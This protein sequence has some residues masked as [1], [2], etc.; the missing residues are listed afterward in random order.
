MT[1]SGAT[2][3]VASVVGTVDPSLLVQLDGITLKSASFV[4]ADGTTGTVRATS[5]AVNAIFV[6]QDLAQ[7]TSKGV[8]TVTGTG[9]HL[10]ETDVTSGSKPATL[11]FTTKGG[12]GLIPVDT[13]DVQ[14]SAAAIAGSGI[15]LSGNLTVTG[16]VG[17]VTLHDLTGQ[18]NIGGTPASA[19]STWKLGHVAGLVFNSAGPVKS[20][21]SSDWQGGSITAPAIGSLTTNGD[22]KRLIAG[23]FSAD[24]TVPGAVGTAK[25]A[26][27]LSG[28]WTVGGNVTSFACAEIADGW[29]A[30]VTGSVGT[31]NGGSS[32]TGSLSAATLTTFMTKGQFSGTLTLTG[33]NAKGVSLGAFSAG[34]VL[35]GAIHAAG[36]INTI[37]A[38]EWL[39]GTLA[40]GSISSLTTAGD[41]THGIAGDF[42]AG[43]VILGSVGTAKIAGQLSGDWTV[44]GNVTSIT[45]KDIVASWFGFVTGNVGTLNGGSS[46]A[47]S[48]SAATLTALMTT[49]QFSGTLT[50]TGENAKGVSLGALQ[51]G[52]ATDGSIHAAGGIST[53]KASEWLAG[54]LTAGWMGSLTTIGDKKHGVAGDFAADVAL[55]NNTVAQTL[56]NLSIAGTLRNAQVAAAGHVGSVALGAMNGSQLLVGTAPA[57][58]GLPQ[59]ASAFVF[60]PAKPAKPSL[61]SFTIKG[62]VANQPSLV[63]SVI[64]AWSIGKG[65]L[66]LVDSGPEASAF[67]FGADTIGSLSF[68]ADGVN[69]GKVVS[70]N[71]LHTTADLFNPK[72]NPSGVLFPVG[73]FT[74]VFV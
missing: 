46:L 71:S 70:L 72:K 69:A 20:L 41:K 18:V 3:D 15:D 31:V 8:V 73:E 36:G 51:A 9:V 2:G 26:G 43:L 47:G 38:T 57:V 61:A 49:G 28:D 50:L 44:G 17:T 45:S 42:D 10:L 16:A 12:T 62:L 25:I 39:A 67:G 22:K 74:L 21:T 35:D 34:N 52:D 60:T 19:G 6:G 58:T 53:I 37:K 55:S 24:V 68:Q 27:Q 29:S 23:D 65:V 14:G 30:I 56:A 5:G 13:I 1:F 54:D 32:L 66:K 7:S 40:A 64:D 4:D 63:A 11:T 59:D 33:E 48:L